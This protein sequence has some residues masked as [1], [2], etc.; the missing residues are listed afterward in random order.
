MLDTEK[1]IKVEDEK[2]E[3]IEQKINFNTLC[4]YSLSKEI[5][6]KKINIDHKKRV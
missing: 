4:S 5:L 2:L 6:H 3:S 1:L